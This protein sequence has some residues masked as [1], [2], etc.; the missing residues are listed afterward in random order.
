MVIIN[1]IEGD[2]LKTIFCYEIDKLADLVRYNNVPIETYLKI[3]VGL[4]EKPRTREYFETHI[5]LIKYI[6]WDK[7]IKSEY[8]TPISIENYELNVTKNNVI[9]E[10]EG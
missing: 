4:K 7:N 6:V 10:V 8:I 1:K 9:K 5:E 2:T 3:V